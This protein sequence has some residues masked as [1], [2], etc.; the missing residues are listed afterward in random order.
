VVETVQHGGSVLAIIV[1]KPASAPGVQFVTPPELSQQLAFMAH[2]AGKRIAP[3]IHLPVSRALETTQEVLVLRAGRLRVDFFD[4]ERRYLESRVVTA[5]D[6]IVL[7]HGGHGFQVLEAVD[8][9]EIKQG[10][11]AG[12]NDKVRFDPAP[13]D[14]RIP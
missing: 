1:R 14:P 4:D 7:V 13:F 3:H 10:P 2:P 12:E 5:G 6:T 9:I 11:Y 8:M